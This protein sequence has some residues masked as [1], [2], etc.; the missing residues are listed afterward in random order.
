MGESLI[1]V[2]VGLAIVLLVFL[3][4]REIVCWYFKLNKINETLIEIRDLLKTD[5]TQ[6][7]E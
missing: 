6:S 1:N 2:L 4:C 7:T 5:R 3:I